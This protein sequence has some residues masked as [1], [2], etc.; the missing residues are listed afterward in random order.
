M[1]TSEIKLIQTYLTNSNFYEYDINGKLDSNTNLAIE[2]ALSS[3]SSELP[4][5][6]LVWTSTRKA[7]AYLQCICNELDIE[8]G[9]I[10]GLYGPQTESASHLLKVLHETGALP[11]AFADI[12]PVRANPHNFPIERDSE[13]NDS[14]GQP[15]SARLVKVACPWELR[16]DWNLRSTTNTI[17]IHE[18]LSDSLAL[19]LNNAYDIYGIEG[20]KKYGLDRYGGSFNCRKKRGSTTSW[21]THAWG[22]SID[23]YPSKNKLKWDSE[24][25]S[26]AHQDL[27]QWWELWER[28]G[29]LSLGRSEDRDWMHVQAAK[30]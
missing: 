3:Y 6:W 12:V 22:I 30:R 20:I 27:D 26:L 5:N 2:S 17:S 13:L 8:T 15:C 19:I 25:S 18:K 4:D 14:Y 29:W 11:R 24:K 16:L 1:K 28:E 21:S 9:D 7:I 23:W 10:D